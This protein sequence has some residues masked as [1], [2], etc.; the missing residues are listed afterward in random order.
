MLVNTFFCILRD[1]CEILSR[2]RLMRLKIPSFR[3]RFQHF[4]LH[5]PLSA[6]RGVDQPFIG[7]LIKLSPN[8]LEIPVQIERFHA[9]S[10]PIHKITVVGCDFFIRFCVQQNTADIAGTPYIFVFNVGE[11]LIQVAGGGD[12]V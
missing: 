7:N 11:D 9:D 2:L 12:I 10:V 5:I 3:N 4:F 8:P 6:L 1:L